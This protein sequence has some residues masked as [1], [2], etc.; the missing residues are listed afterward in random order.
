MVVYE[1]VCG[2]I[3]RVMYG[4]VWYGM[5]WSDMRKSAGTPGENFGWLG[6]DLDQDLRCFVAFCR[7]SEIMQF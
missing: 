1:N 2:T 5:V 4:M 6:N 7:L 3:L